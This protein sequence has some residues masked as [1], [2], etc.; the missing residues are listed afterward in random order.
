[1]IDEQYL[2]GFFDGEGCVAIYAN[3]KGNGHTLSVQIVQNKSKEVTKFMELLHGL[4]GGGL[5]VSKSS[6]GNEK[7][8]LHITGPNAADFLYKVTPNLKFKRDQAN[9]CLAWY[10]TRPKL[11]RDERGRLTS[12]PPE[13]HEFDKKVARLVKAL[14]K[15]DID[16]VMANQ[17]DLVEVVHQLKQVLCIKGN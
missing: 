14:K 17:T 10:L 3:G 6:N 11:K 9:F 13:Q 12:H 4:F 7:Y 16:A 15:Q 1:M 8:N 5:S 2:A